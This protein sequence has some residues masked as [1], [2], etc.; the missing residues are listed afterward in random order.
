MK[1]PQSVKLTLLL[2]LLNSLVLNGCS[3]SHKNPNYSATKAIPSSTTV[4]NGTL[5]HNGVYGDSTGV[6]LIQSEQIQ[7]NQEPE[8]IGQAQA[9]AI[10]SKHYARSYGVGFEEALKRMLI[11]EETGDQ[12]AAIKAEFGNR[13]TGIGYAYEPE[14]AIQVTLTG[15]GVPPAPRMLYRNATKLKSRE[16]VAQ[17]YKIGSPEGI[18]LTQ[19][20][21]DRAMTLIESPTPFKVIFKVNPKARNL[22]Q[23]EQ[24]LFNKNS[25]TLI[26]RLPV[27][28]LMNYQS[29]EGELV[30]DVNAIDAKK[31][32]LSTADIQQ[33]AQ[34]I[35]QLPVKVNLVNY[36]IVE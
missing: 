19:S 29:A 17:A 20:E 30:L 31:A 36:R 18:T 1:K 5:L 4:T 23:K 22:T 11:Q 25:K 27:I 3:T 15:N 21:L 34:A 13:I 26:Q 7:A 12:I 33:K 6:S 16:T 8:V 2:F 14:F 9:L 10:D 28:M 32:G 35:M 24:T